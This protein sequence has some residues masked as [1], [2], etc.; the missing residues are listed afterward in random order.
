MGSRAKE[1]HTSAIVLAGT[2]CSHSSNW[3]KEIQSF[4]WYHLEMYSFIRYWYSTQKSESLMRYRREMFALV[5]VVLTMHHAVLS[6]LVSNVVVTQRKFYKF[7]L[8][9]RQRHPFISFVLAKS[10]SGVSVCNTGTLLS[11]FS[12]ASH[13]LILGGEKKVVAKETTVKYLS[14]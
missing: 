3:T 9:D 14:I 5:P 7:S 4:S 11:K 1:K 8:Q 6:A 10:F 12:Q 13:F 2:L